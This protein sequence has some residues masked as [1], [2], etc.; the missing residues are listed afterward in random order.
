MKILIKLGQFA[1]FIMLAFILNYYQIK[2]LGRQRFT[3][4]MKFAEIKNVLIPGSGKAYYNG[5]PN[6][7][8]LGRLDTAA[9]I[10]K[11][12]PM[13]RLILSGIE[14]YRYNHEPMD[15]LIALRA[16]GI[17]DSVCI[18][19]NHGPD[20][21]ETLEN[22]RENFGSE[23]VII[24]T[25]NE[26]LERALWIAGKMGIDARGYATTGYKDSP[27]NW[28]LFREFGARIKARIEVMIYL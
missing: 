26:H 9:A 16:R 1:L 20:T 22:Y 2:Y 27:I 15:M 13:N 8:L 14:D 11:D 5:I 17:P 6:L 23:P 24:I 28:I 12:Y 18:L 3:D 7:T 19:D 21:F 10:W 25:Q 4:R